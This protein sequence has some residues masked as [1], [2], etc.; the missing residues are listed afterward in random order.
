MQLNV[1]NEFDL[2]FHKDKSGSVVGYESSPIFEISSGKR[3]I[4]V[5][6]KVSEFSS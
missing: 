3:P 1:Q 5:A 2:I 4:S 6:A